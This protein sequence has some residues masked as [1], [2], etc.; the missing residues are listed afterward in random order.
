ML[1]FSITQAKNF[2]TA[3]LGLEKA[4]GPEI[5]LLTYGGSWRK[6]GNSRKNIYPCF[7]DYAKA[8]DCVDHKKTVKRSLKDGNIRPSYPSPE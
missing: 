1:N 7:T 2:Q 6:Q 3:K 5:Q 8:F 4:E